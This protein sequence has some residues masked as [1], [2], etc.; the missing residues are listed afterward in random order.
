MKNSGPSERNQKISLFVCY[1]GEKH[2]CEPSQGSPIVTAHYPGKRL[3]LKA[4]L[5]PT[6]CEVGSCILGARCAEDSPIK[7]V[8][9]RTPWLQVDL[10]EPR[11]ASSHALGG[12]A[13][14]ALP[15]PRSRQLS[16]E[17]RVPGFKAGGG[18]GELAYKSLLLS[19]LFHLL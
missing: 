19:R 11:R 17:L 8:R 6:T 15:I 1:R 16:F 4:L 9:T 3:N 14:A 5:A 7:P 12:K 18:L 13:V 10:C 2:V